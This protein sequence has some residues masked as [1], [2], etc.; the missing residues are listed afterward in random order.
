M[1]AYT[2][3]ESDPRVRREAEALA[4]RG[5]AVTVWSLRAEGFPER[6]HSNGVTVVRVELPRYRGGKALAYVGSYGRFFAVATALVTAAHVEERFD[7]VH[8]HT[9]PDFMV[10]AALV[11][12]LAGAKVLL[13]MHDLMPELYAL[14]FGLAKRGRAVRAL[15]LV[16]RAATSFAD[17]VLCV[18]Q[19]QY[20]LLLRDGVPAYKLGIVMNAADPKLFPP[21][22]G[23]PVTGPSDPIRLVY[24]GTV[25]R[26]YGVDLAVRAF[27]KA[28]ARDPR[29]VMT[30]LG[31]GDFVDE[32]KALAAE[33]GLGPDVFT[34][35]GVHKPLDEIARVIRD[36]HIGVVP[37]RDDQE[38]SVLPT[39]L[40][41]YISVGIPAVATKT[42]CIARFFERDE[43]ELVEVGDVDG[44]ADAIVRLAS[45]AKRRREL[46]A[47]GRKWEEEYGWAVNRQNLF[48]AIDALCAEKLA[49]ER[50]ASK[51]AKASS[52]GGARAAS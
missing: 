33:L 31:G 39:K 23:E 22:D 36:A 38:D 34:M 9:M 27:A 19:N 12:R 4:A 16:Q 40:L 35:P 47:K 42:R 25:L 14:K 48:R 11:P 5:D 46:V 18:H 45:D 21:R 10:F 24:H 28:R 7:V 43:V 15:R 1:I 3:Y 29:L 20:E 50:Q 8:V 49:A 52:T 41:E 51:A 17:V 26:R 2:H 30:L 37:N 44:M 32:V 13:D 6:T